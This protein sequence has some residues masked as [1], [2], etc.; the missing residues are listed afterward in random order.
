MLASPWLGP[1]RA[2]PS[3]EAVEPRGRVGVARWGGARRRGEADAV[4][5][6]RQRVRRVDGDVAGLAQERVVG[7]AVPARPPPHASV[8]GPRRARA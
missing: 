6:A 4:V 3:L 8:A 1:R 7:G 2:R 5:A